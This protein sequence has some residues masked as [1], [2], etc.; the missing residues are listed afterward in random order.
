MLVTCLDSKIGYDMASK[1]VKNAHEKGT[2]LEQSALELGPST[3]D[4]VRIT[5]LSREW[6]SGLGR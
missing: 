6:M 4:E 1:V 2:T 5:L 3:I